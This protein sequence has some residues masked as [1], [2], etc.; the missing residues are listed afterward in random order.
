[1]KALLDLGLFVLDPARWTTDRKACLQSI[2]ALSIHQ[3][4]LRREPV[5]L[6]WSDVFL[7]GF[8]WNQPQCPGELID[9]CNAMTQLH[10]S[11]RGQGRVLLLTNLPAHPYL[12]GDVRLTPDL[13]DGPFP[14]RLQDEVRLLATSAV[15][16]LPCEVSAPAAPRQPIEGV[17]EVTVHVEP[18]TDPIG[19]AHLLFTDDDW[20]AFLRR[21]KRPVLGGRRVAV[22]GGA[23]ASFERARKKLEAFGAPEMRRLP[24]AFEE[25]R[26][27]QETLQR[28]EHVDLLVVCTNRCKHTDTD[29]LKDGVPC[30][31]LDLNSD[32]DTALVQAVLDHFRDKT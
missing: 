19:T 7:E 21:F 6:L 4:W 32:G 23:R 18:E 1:M 27:K 12:A 24:P 10:D 2:A 14:P 31:R 8:P 29:H 17:R 28:L 15:L 11:L 13:A 3:P 5:R 16:D 25:T 26:T 9:L 20:R 22:L 30:A